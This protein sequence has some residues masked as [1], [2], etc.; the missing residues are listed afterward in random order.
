MKNQILT[1]LGIMATTW[2]VGCSNGGGNSSS[3]L[4]CNGAV[5][6]DGNG[7][8]VSTTGGVTSSVIQFYDYKF[9]FS[10]DSGAY[11]PNI[12][13]SLTIVNSGAYKQFLKSAMAVCDISSIS[14]GGASCDTWL[15]GSL[16]VSFSIDSSMQPR[17][18]FRAVPGQSFF[19]G[20]LGFYTGGLTM[21]PLKLY[22]N[23]TYSL[24][25]NSQGFELRANGSALNGGG[26]NLIQIQVVK[27]TLSDSS[28]DYKLIYP[29]GGVATTFATGTFK[30]Y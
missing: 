12:P 10:L 7:N 8:I 2:L 1:V 21:N 26:L 16:Q 29:Y 28:F 4:N 19:Y 22:G 5:C 11:S 14:W 15:Q 3:F 27:G 25:N 6:I 24:I 20:N 30:R 17:I 23:T 9:Y 13:G 18:D